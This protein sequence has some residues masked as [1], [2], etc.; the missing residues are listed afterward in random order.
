MERESME[1]RYIN[2]YTDFGFKKLFKAAEI[3]KFTTAEYE[4]YEESLKVYRDW[5]NT[6]ATAEMKALDKGRTE[7]RAEGRAEG[8]KE[9]KA[10]GLKE[11]RAE[12]L[13]EGKAEGLKEGRAEGLKKGKAEGRTEEKQEIARRM[14]AAGLP[15]SSIVEITG[16]GAEEINGL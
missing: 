9:G 13:K 8:L 14:R 2:P 3:A 12:G 16:L 5:R 11:G 1:A 4:A 7:G 15:V 10:E 6:I